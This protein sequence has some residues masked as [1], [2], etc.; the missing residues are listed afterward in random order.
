MAIIKCENCGGNV[1]DK[2]K[3]CPHCGRLINH[4]ASMPL[5][6]TVSSNSAVTTSYKEPTTKK[7][8]T[9]IAI[10]SSIIAVLA[11]AVAGYFWQEGQRI[12]DSIRPL[13]EAANSGDAD[14]QFKLGQY[15]SVDENADKNYKE[16]AK[17]L[18]KAA[19]QGHAEAQ[20]KYG[21]LLHTDIV[22]EANIIEAV[23]WLR[24]SAEQGYGKAQ[25][26]L[27]DL[28]ENGVGVP[29]DLSE[30]VRWY[31]LAAEQGNDDAID[32]LERLG[33]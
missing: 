31:R 24:K 5:E 29:R 18:G 9:W 7:K 33:Y 6:P 2:A 23:K 15:Y 11:L 12:P 14:A 3:T 10:C 8:K 27:G 1:S 17:W 28:Y 4:K 25:M 30:A 21:W 19:E 32:A 16:A 26:Q 20:F 13:Y 22:G